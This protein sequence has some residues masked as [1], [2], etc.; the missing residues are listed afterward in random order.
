MSSLISL[1]RLHRIFL[2]DT[3]RW[4]IEPICFPKRGY[5]ITNHT[6]IVHMSPMLR[7]P[8]LMQ[9]RTISSKISLCS[10]YMLIRDDAFSINRIFAKE[11]PR[12]NKNFHKS[13]K[14][15]P[16]LA[17]VDCTGLSGMTPYAHSLSSVF[18]ERGSNAFA[19]SLPS[20][21]SVQLSMRNT[22]ETCV[23]FLFFWAGDMGLWERKLRAPSSCLPLLASSW[24]QEMNPV[25]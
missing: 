2:D 21:L 14:C 8:G 7:K 17:Y 10:L 1:T 5:R 19:F 15:R 20:M 16:R 12:F 18:P 3:L 11:E 22:T 23:S 13:G 6:I 4:C 25:S 24:D 9:V